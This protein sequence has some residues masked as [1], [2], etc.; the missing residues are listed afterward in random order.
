MHTFFP[1]FARDSKVIPSRAF[2]GFRT[3]HRGTSRPALWIRFRNWMSSISLN[4]LLHRAPSNSVG[5]AAILASSETE[6]GNAESIEILAVGSGAWDRSVHDVLR[7]NPRLH[8]CSTEDP[9]TLWLMLAQQTLHVIVLNCSLSKYELEEVGRLARRRWPKAKI[10]V[11]RDGEDFMEDALYDDR[12]FSSRNP[13]SFIASIERMVANVMNGG[14]LR[15]RQLQFK[16]SQP[17]AGSINGQQAA[18]LCL[19][20]RRALQLSDLGC[21]PLDDR[22]K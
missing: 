19:G 4:S 10:L 11:I 3:S 12:I 14:V 5:E 7:S 2:P 21:R 15:A 16:Q 22:R 17:S 6:N 20:S 9:R 13:D 8:L 18:L 1:I